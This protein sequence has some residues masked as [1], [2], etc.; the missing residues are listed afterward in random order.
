MFHISM[1]SVGETS[2]LNVFSVGETSWSRCSPRAL[3][4]ASDGEGNPL[5]CACGMRGPKP[6]GEGGSI[7]YRSAGAC[8]PRALD[9]ADAGAGNPLACACGMRGP[10]PYGEGGSIFYRSAG[11]CPPRWPA[12]KYVFKSV[13]TYMSIAARVVPFLR[14]F[15]VLDKNTRGPGK[16]Y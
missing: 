1:C 10:K 4:D 15:R 16:N 13:S 12:S 5:A 14:S 11:A 2:G 7:F 8:P 3:D 6:Y 9:D